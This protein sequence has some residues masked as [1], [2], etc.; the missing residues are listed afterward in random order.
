[1]IRRYALIGILIGSLSG[2]QTSVA[3]AQQGESPAPIQST[4]ATGGVTEPAA[5]DAQQIRTIVVPAGTQIAMTLASAITTKTSKPSDPVRA[6]T[7]FPVTVGT[8]L[9]IPVGTYAE[10]AIDKVNRRGRNGPSVEMHFTRLLFA[11]GYTVDITAKNMV[12]RM[13]PAGGSPTE[14]AAFTEEK[15]ANGGE[16]SQ[17]GNALRGQQTGG[18]PPMPPAPSSH[19][20][21][22]V[23][24]GLGTT[25][26]FVIMLILLGHHAGNGVNG[27]IFDTG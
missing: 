4:T 14:A 12:A 27:V 13:L 2:G 5:A 25:A 26:A 17:Q 21:T 20:G 6:V 1:M 24:I 7:A 19:I 11:D 10:G 3:I 18:L 9:A 8:Q 15:S 23:A 22:A 16:E